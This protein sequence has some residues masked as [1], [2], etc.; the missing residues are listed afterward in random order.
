MAAVTWSLYLAFGLMAVTNEQLEL[1]IW[2]IVWRW[3]I[4]VTTYEILLESQELQI[5]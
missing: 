3:N 2:N 1:G 4:N 5:W